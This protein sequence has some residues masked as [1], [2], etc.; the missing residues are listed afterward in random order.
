MAQRGSGF[1]RVA[2]DRYETP[3]HVAESIAPYLRAHAIRKIWEPATAP[4]D[5]L[6]N[7]LRRAGFTVVSTHDNFLK[8]T[9]LPD[10]DAI[11]TNP[12][13]G[14][15]GKRACS[16]IERATWLARHVVFLLPIDFDSAITR[17]RL[18]RDH[19]AFAHKV[20][21]LGRVK[22]FAGPSEPSTNHA[23]YCWDRSHHGPLTFSY[24]KLAKHGRA[25][26]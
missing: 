8:R 19:P 4:S 10:I 23:W 21:L 24:A 6:G 1:A 22:W 11:V 3:D 9:A 2:D 14:T 17:P 15:Q 20:V 12:P 5:A 25:S 7:A 26:R 16:F 18:F 13:Y